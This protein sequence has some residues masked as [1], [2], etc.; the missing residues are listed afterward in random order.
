MKKVDFLLSYEHKVREAEA[1]ML[2]KLV[3]ERLG[4]S[5]DIYCSYE[6][7][8]KSRL[9]PKVIVVPAAYTA[10]V[11]ECFAINPGGFC[12]K[13]ANLQWEQLI[14]EEEE[15]DLAALHN[16]KGI[17]RQVL[18]FCWGQNTVD[19]LVASG[20]P[21]DC[22]RLTGGIHIDFLRNE[23]SCFLKS[24][25]ELANMAN[26]PLDKSWT[27][28]ISSFSLTNADP[29]VMEL[30]KSWYSED[31]ACKLLDWFTKSRNEILKWLEYYVLQNPNKVLIYRPHPDEVNLGNDLQQLE[32][33]YSNF[34]VVSVDSVKQWINQCDCCFN[35]YSTSAADVYFLNKPCLILRPIPTPIDQEVVI[36]KGARFVKSFDEFRLLA[37][38]SDPWVQPLDNNLMHGYYGNDFSGEP[39]FMKIVS[40]LIELY[41]SPKGNLR[42]GISLKVYGI[43]GELKNTLMS[44]FMKHPNFPLINYV[45][46][47][48]IEKRRISEMFISSGVDRN[49]LT[50]QEINLFKIKL[51]PIIDKF[52]PLQRKGL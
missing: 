4:Y 9:T 37:S 11:L 40:K 25:E 31:L 19:R 41:N 43:I 48:K 10:G 3:L 33:K 42:Y 50:E 34:R 13:V 17:A 5:V 1:V 23:F 47:R 24:K 18:H 32:K 38:S 30:L 22:C 26:L 51:A 44:I 16:P 29:S 21:A 49:V 52:Y 36:M 7:N 14:T 46:G 12:G 6:C 15:K 35:W 20:V 28:M 8:I 27:L 45:F 2:L 39:A